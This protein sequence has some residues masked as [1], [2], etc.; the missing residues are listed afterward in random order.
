M[1]T[2]LIQKNTPLKF[3]IKSTSPTVNELT[4][5]I[6]NELPDIDKTKLV[7]A[8]KKTL[9]TILLNCKMVG[10]INN[11]R[12]RYSRNK[13]CYN[14]PVRYRY[15]N[16]RY[17]TV[18]PVIDSLGKLK[19]IRNDVEVQSNNHSLQSTFYPTD[20][21]LNKLSP[22]ESDMYYFTPYPDPIILRDENGTSIDYKD[23]NEIIQE[24]KELKAYNDIRSLHTLSVK[25]IPE[26]IL[27]DEDTA[28][29]LERCSYK[30]KNE[31][32][33]IFKPTYAHR[34]YNGSFERGGRYY[35]TIETQIPGVLRPLILI[36]EEETIEVDYSSYHIRLLYH[37]KGIDYKEDA[38][39][40]L[41]NGD[42]VLR[43]VFKL[44]GLISINAKNFN[45]A[46]QGYLNDVKKESP[47]KGFTDLSYAQVKSC[48]ERWMEFH[49][50]I[51]EYFFSDAGAKLQ[52][53]DSKIAS[54]VI[55]HFVELGE[56]IL[57]I[58]DSFIVKK[59][60]ESELKKLM[61]STYNNELGFTPVLE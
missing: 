31:N 25:N 15:E 16:K 60:L 21:L 10:S 45:A 47:L 27:A 34:V 18:V 11:K 14:G 30:S 24:R 8:K 17:S 20:E 44:I 7:N 52:N 51:K 57:C 4:E 12:I 48:M 42:P 59:S 43:K 55:K 49:S 29:I 37:L 19:Y 26:E 56:M 54:K 35:G 40:V 46:V 41:A 6:W 23:T 5:Q 58:H 28:M 36:N 38:Y 61:T 1:V 53:I 3:N 50:D 9:K 33:L 32:E 39:G 2:P 13:N 22:V